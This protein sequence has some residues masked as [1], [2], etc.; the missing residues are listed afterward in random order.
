MRST[1]RY[2]TFIHT[3]Q[4]LS[5][6]K[7]VV[8]EALQIDIEEAICAN[9]DGTP[10]E[11]GV[12]KIRVARPGMGKRGGVRVIYYYIGRRGR[13]YL[14]DVYAKNEKAALSAKEKQIV[15]ALA[16]QFEEER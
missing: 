11:A 7:G 3:Q 9:P 5:A 16:R 12:R 6:G 15:R 4:Y 10:V 13:V 1:R 8:D 2:L 14:I